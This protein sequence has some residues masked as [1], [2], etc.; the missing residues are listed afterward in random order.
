[1]DTIR[2]C[3]LLSASGRRSWGKFRS[4]ICEFVRFRPV[5]GEFRGGLKRDLKESAPAQLCLPA[6]IV[7]CYQAAMKSRCLQDDRS[8]ISRGRRKIRRG[9]SYF[10]AM[11][12]QKIPRNVQF[13]RT[14]D[15]LRE[16]ACGLGIRGRP[17]KRSAARL[18][19]ASLSRRLRPSDRPKFSRSRRVLAP[20]HPRKRAPGHVLG[21]AFPSRSVQKRGC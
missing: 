5:P 9:N 2:Y 6:F 20:P 8:F 15:S 7:R 13:A 11:F 17:A 10:R 12:S 19:A 3:R 21:S 18:R 1:M 4:L 16:P 14:S